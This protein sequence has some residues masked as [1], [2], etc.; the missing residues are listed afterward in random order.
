MSQ[1][2]QHCEPV[3]TLFEN[4]NQG[5]VGEYIWRHIR[6]CCIY[7]KLNAS[8]RCLPFQQTILEAL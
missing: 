7:R 2:L 4:A 3:F 8:S 1:E 6:G 5:A